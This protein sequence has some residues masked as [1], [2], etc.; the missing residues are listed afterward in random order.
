LLGESLVGQKE[1]AEAEPLLLS[2]YDGLKARDAKIPAQSKV[3]LT[4]T[5]ERVAQLY[6]STGRKQEAAAWRAK[7]QHPPSQP[8]HKP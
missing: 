3:G 6:E 1:Y 2:G 5:G 7:V 8:E 4:K